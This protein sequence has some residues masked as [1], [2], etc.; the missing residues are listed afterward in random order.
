[1]VVVI[2]ARASSIVAGSSTVAVTTVPKFTSSA[3]LDSSVSFENAAMT[4]FRDRP[5]GRFEVRR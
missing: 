4:S 3:Q 2:A 5:V 1:M